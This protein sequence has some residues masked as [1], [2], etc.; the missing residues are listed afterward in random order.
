MNRYGQVE[1][2]SP[3]SRWPLEQAG[4]GVTGMSQS[5]F[6]EIR[7]YAELKLQAVLTAAT[8]GL[9]TQPKS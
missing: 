9:E 2:P 7:V 4:W 5:Q 1:E 8:P 3:L 6:Q